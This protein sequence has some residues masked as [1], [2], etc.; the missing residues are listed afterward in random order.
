MAAITEVSRKQWNHRRG[1]AEVCS[2]SQHT[3]TALKWMSIEGGW[4]Y[5]NSHGGQDAAKFGNGS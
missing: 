2:A 4:K 3:S 1:L 5:C